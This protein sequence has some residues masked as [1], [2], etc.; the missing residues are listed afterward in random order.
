MIDRSK[1]LRFDFW[2]LIFQNRFLTFESVIDSVCR[3]GESL[4]MLEIRRYDDADDL[5]HVEYTLVGTKLSRWIDCDPEISGMWIAQNYNILEYKMSCSRKE[6]LPGD[7]DFSEIIT[8]V[9]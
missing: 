1:H 2:I 7:I 3:S 9:F 8:V 6:G 4:R 5:S